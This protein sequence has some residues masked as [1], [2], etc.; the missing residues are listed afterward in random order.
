MSNL[1]DTIGN[2]HL[3]N[4]TNYSFVQDRY[5]HLNSCIYFQNGYLQ[6]P[7]G[8]YFSSDFTITIW[9]KLKSYQ[10]YS[11]IIDFGN[12]KSKDMVTIFFPEKS[13]KIYAGVWDDLNKESFVITSSI[14]ELNKWYHVAFVCKKNYG[15]I[16]VNGGQIASTNKLLN[17][18]NKVRESN[19]IGKSNSN[20]SHA[21]AVYDELKIYSGSLS[22]SELLDDYIRGSK[23]G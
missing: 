9:I 15:Y 19:F 20:D 17:P 18:K 10:S 6:V 21:D 16:Y 5:G 2:A 11:R 13:S 12:G 3:S 1:S 4:G 8:V 14:L 22:S 23:N 7:S